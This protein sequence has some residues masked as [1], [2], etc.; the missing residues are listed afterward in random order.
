MS[1]LH[2]AQN[3]LVYRFVV[4]YGITISEHTEYTCNYILVG[5]PFLTKGELLYYHVCQHRIEPYVLH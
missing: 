2:G 4:T 1:S 3:T 5:V